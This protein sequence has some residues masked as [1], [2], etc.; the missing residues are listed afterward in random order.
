MILRRLTRPILSLP[1][2]RHH[3]FP[4]HIIRLPQHRS[5]S[6]ES[7]TT[8]FNRAELRAA[9]TGNP[10]LNSEYY[11]V[12]IGTIPLIKANVGPL[13]RRIA[14]YKI[15]AF[16]LSACGLALAP[17]V[18]ATAEIPLMALPGTT[19]PSSSPLYNTF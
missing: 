18:A 6:L 5:I 11:L 15:G 16:L 4:H 2:C 12:Y 10:D 19:T 3:R 13:S 1:Q 17:L 8:P 7:L 9:A 14:T